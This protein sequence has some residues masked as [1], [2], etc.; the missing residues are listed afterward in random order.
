MLALGSVIV[1][2]SFAETLARRNPALAYALAPAKGRIAAELA[3]AEFKADPSGDPQSNAARLPLVSLRADPTAVKAVTVLGLQAQIRNHTESARRYFAYSE[4]L[5]RRNFNTQLWAVED[6]VARGDISGALQHYDIALRTTR[7]AADVLFPILTA[8]ITDPQIRT[9]L[10]ATLSE[11]PIWTVPFIRYLVANGSNAASAGSLYADLRRAGVSIPAEADEAV[12]R[13]LLNGD[14]ADDAWRYYASVRRGA[15][16]RR[17]RDPRF[18]APFTSPTAFDWKASTDPNLG[19]I[20]QRRGEGGVF[21]FATLAGVSGTLLQQTQMLPPGRYRLNGHSIGIEQADSE[22]PF[23]TLTC[24][25]GVKL[26]RISVPNS[27]WD[28]GNFS[29]TFVVPAG[30][31]V[32]TLT[33]IASPTDRVE[34]VTGQFDQ[35]QIAPDD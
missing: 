17:S 35:V 11:K 34:G 2:Q 31:P 30:C 15:D 32:Q 20:F 4:R 12:V 10:A 18:V 19:A 9:A 26:A 1:A 16:P 25:G 5:S 22:R 8:A 7:A 14:E 28:N 3:D 13:N 23:W 29:S 27:A 33:L 6:A 24:K 21:Q